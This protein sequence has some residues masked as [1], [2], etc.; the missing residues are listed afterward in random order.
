EVWS[1]WE[2]IRCPTLILRGVDS[3][4]LQRDTVERMR[5]SAAPVEVVELPGI[6]HAPS[7]MTQSQIETVRDF[8]LRG[9]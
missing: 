5:R 9:T 7:L 6:G 8:L 1:V 4:V 3:E 2:A